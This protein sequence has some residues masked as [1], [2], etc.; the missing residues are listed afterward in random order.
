[1]LQITL[2]PRCGFCA[3]EMK[4]LSAMTN[5]GVTIHC[6]SECGAVLGITKEE[7]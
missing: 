1:M 5:S 2:R 3:K 7:K 6:C 4:K